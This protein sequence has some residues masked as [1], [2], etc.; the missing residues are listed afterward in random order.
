MNIWKNK[1]WV[2]MLLERIDKPFN[3]KDYIF[4]L[5]FDGIRT[6]IFAN[7]E[8]IIIKN[9]N[10]TDVTHLYPELQNI[11]NIVNSNTIFDGEIIC[12]ENGEPSFKKLQERSHL[13][14]NDKILYHMEN[15]PAVFICFDIVYKDKDLTKL[16]LL[17]RK[18]ILSL[19]K[20]T[21]S[22][23]KTKYID[24]DGI[25]LFNKVKKLNLEGIIAKKKNSIYKI[26][27]RDNSWI[28]IK[29]LRMEEFIIGGYIEEKKN[30]VVSLLLGE[31]IKNELH[32]VG[33][34]LM[35]KKNK[36]YS[37][38]IHSKTLK[39]SPFK[40]HTDDEAIYTQ[41]VKTCKIKYLERTASNRLRQPIFVK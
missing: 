17:K 23:I 37:E 8:K 41:P 20:D 40:N 2:P 21:E 32:F 19:F 1:N 28:K 25:K 11:K 14:G 18:E 31:I 10:K 30:F 39:N 12:F 34:V 7:P 9:R 22:F 4:E 27:T 5:K 16:P 35:G 24:T 15:N 3:S 13:K 38:L 36:L 33:K 6:L 26:N 29:N